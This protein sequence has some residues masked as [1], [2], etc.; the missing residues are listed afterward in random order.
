MFSSNFLPYNIIVGFLR[1]PNYNKV[2]K[3]FKARVKNFPQR[4]RTLFNPL[5][6]IYF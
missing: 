5:A 3:K 4:E 1:F 6:C 2:R